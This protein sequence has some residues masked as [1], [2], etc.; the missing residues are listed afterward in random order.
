MDVPD[1]AS[2]FAAVL[3][4]SQS[5]AELLL[6][7]YDGIDH[8]SDHDD[9]A[10]LRRAVGGLKDVIET[11]RVRLDKE[12]TTGLGAS[13]RLITALRDSLPHLKRIGDDFDIGRKTV[14]NGCVNSRTPGR[15]FGSKD[16]ERYVQSLSRCKMILSL[17]LNLAEQ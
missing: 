6:Q 10:Q 15:P 17:G 14:V 5:V 8:A 3:Q 4:S 12:L 9:V 16:V 7:D 2:S 1:G 13:S 11:V